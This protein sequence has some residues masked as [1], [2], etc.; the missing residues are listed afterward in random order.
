MTRV[1]NAHTHK[2]AVTR[3]GGFVTAMIFRE[4]HFKISLSTFLSKDDS[5]FFSVDPIQQNSIF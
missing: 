4:A 5:S 3:L 2:H 1:N